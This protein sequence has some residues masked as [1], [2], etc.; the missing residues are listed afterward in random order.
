MNKTPIR[1]IAIAIL[2]LIAAGSISADAFG[3]SKSK[4][5][6]SFSKWQAQSIFSFSDSKTEKT[7][8]QMTL[9]E[10][11]G[12][13]IIAQTEARSGITTDRATQQLGRL[14]QEGKVGG[15]MF[16]K[17]DAF[18]AALLSNYFQS[19]TARPL[20]MSADMERGLAMRLSGATE[21][22]PNMALAATKETKFAFEMAKAIAKEA[23]IVG[24]HQNYAPTVDLNINPANPII[25][26][27]SFSD[28]PALAI[29]MSNAVIE[30]LQSNGIA[31]TAKHFP[32]HGDVTVDSH[33]SLPVLNAD[34][35][36]LDAYELQPFKAAIDQGI[37][38]IMTGHL[39]VPKL[40]GTMEPAS[41]SKTIVTDLLRK[42]LGF[43]GLI[44][45]DAMNM[46]ALYNGNNVAEISVKAVQ[47]GNDLLLFS[48]DPE[49]A[50][51]AI[52]NAVENGVIPR[53]NIDASVRRILQL[54][55]WLEIEHRKLVD[56]NSVMD[57]ISP[58]AH[59]DLAEKITR[60]SITIAQN[61]NNVIPLKIGSS[62]GNILSIILQDKSNS[63]TGKH[64]IDEI[65][66][67]YPASHLRID[68]KSDDQTFAA[69][70]ELASK[71]PAVVISSY[72][73]VFSGSGTLKL[74]LKQ[75]EFI[76]KLAQSLPAGK[77]LIFISFGTPYLINAFPEIHAHLCAYAANETSETYAVKALRGELS[78]TGTLPVSLQRNSR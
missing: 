63:E 47:A 57:N 7:L 45:T 44:I 49:L 74:T 51:N 2:F 41:I 55:H 24:I 10:K 35:A 53:E 31:A 1:T 29:A 62:S 25:N 11:I 42:D 76:H 8:K 13:M 73:Q 65:N 68:P 4:S 56:L 59:R 46:K 66:R 12:Q 58:S 18:S 71:A 78:P 20:L 72:V 61:V 36:R 9:S 69:A 50:H 5:K 27:R 14:V 33:L 64:Y 19:L 75:Q 60:N 28:N 67:Y 16:M 43:T 3:K 48:P 34:R 30:G 21:F 37:I 38:S 54:K 52:L 17:G 23:R 22:P 15:I 70:L 39:A 26:T 40:T 77:P 6:P 32:G